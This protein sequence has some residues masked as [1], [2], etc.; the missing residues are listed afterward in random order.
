MNNDKRMEYTSSQ[1]MADKGLMIA[2]FKDVSQAGKQI[3]S[4]FLAPYIIVT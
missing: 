4:N 1:N 3:R 2:L